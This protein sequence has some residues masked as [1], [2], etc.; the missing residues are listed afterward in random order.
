MTG[1]VAVIG[2]SDFVMP[3]TALGLDAYA[4]NSDNSSETIATAQDILTK[5]YTMIVVSEDIAE[6]TEKV[7]ETVQHHP[8]PCVV[9]LP[10][11]TESNGFALQALGKT[12]KMATGIDIIHS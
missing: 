2:D 8:T 5:R 11:T 1:K 9:V 3:F 10:F 7:F 6:I 4:V 12:L